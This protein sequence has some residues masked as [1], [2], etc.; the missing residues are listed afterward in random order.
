MTE[1]AHEP[2][3]RSFESWS[4]DTPDDKRARRALLWRALAFARPYRK[5]IALIIGL[6][7]S[8]AVLSVIE[9]LVLRFIFDALATDRDVQSALMGVGIFAALGAARELGSGFV[10]WLT[11]RTRLA[12]Q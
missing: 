7:L 10:T 2:D 1:I 11:W 6:T 9:P 5:R 8:A 12:L 4:P 3:A